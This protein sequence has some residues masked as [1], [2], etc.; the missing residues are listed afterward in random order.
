MK[1]QWLLLLAAAGLL[2]CVASIQYSP[3]LP[4]PIFALLAAGGSLLVGGSLGSLL[5]R[6]F[7]VRD[8]VLT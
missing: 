4:K 6:G 1:K 8:P 5:C 3:H 2:F 7:Q